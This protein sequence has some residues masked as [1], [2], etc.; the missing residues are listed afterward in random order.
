[1]PLGQA[2]TWTATVSGAQAGTLAYRFRVRLASENFHTVVDYG[3]KSSLTWTT[4]DQEGAYELEASVRNIATGETADTNSTF[5]L[6]SLLAGASP[7]ITTSANPL[8]YIYSAPP[9]SPGSRM[10]VEFQAFEGTAQYTPFR[11]CLAG[12][13]MNFYLAGM[14]GGAQYSIRQV[15]ERGTSRNLG[16]VIVYTT[17]MTGASP[18]VTIDTP[19]VSSPLPNTHVITP[20]NSRAVEEILLQSIFLR[21]AVATDLSG[22]LLWY[23]PSDLTYLTSPVAGGTFLALGEDGAKDAS[24][25]FMREFD[26]AGITVAETNA[27]RVTEQLLGMGLRYITGFH[28]DARKLPDGKYLVLAASERILSDVQGA[29]PVDVIGDTIVVLDAN[30]NVLWAWDSFDHLNPYRLAIL[31]ETCTY[32]AG[33]QCPPFFLSKTANDWLHGNAVQFTPDGNILYSAR[34][35]DWVVKIDYNNG[36]GTGGVLWRLGSGGDFTIQ[37]TDPSPWFSHQHDPGFERDGTSLV[38]YDNGNTRAAAKPGSTSRGQV[39]HIDENGRTATLLLNA[40]LGYYSAAVGAAQKLT[41][42]DYHF[43]SGFIYGPSGTYAQSVEVDNTGQ[44]RYRIEIG[45]SAYRSFR[46]RDLYTAP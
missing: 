14:R 38:L 6:T 35:Q 19:A 39:L 46:L 10:R 44:E 28:H 9:C 3:P 7:V 43:D 1:M 33:L 26:L 30:L 20:M 41:N 22:N 37:S 2:V 4:I 34:H 25:Q 17:R 36:A 16:P 45:V 8:V 24:Y 18:A 27:A 15:V 29:G 40:D 13:S 23:S 21:G 42:G 5:V 11:P 12:L 31:G 32:P